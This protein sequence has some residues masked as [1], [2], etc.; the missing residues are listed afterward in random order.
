[1]GRGVSIKERLKQDENKSVL[2]TRGSSVALVVAVREP[3]YEAG[4]PTWEFALFESGSS[5]PLLGA[6]GKLD[7]SL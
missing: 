6:G 2:V 1:M 4:A 3:E 5:A 7:R